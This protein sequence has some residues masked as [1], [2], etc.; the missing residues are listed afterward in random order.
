MSNNLIEC[1]I[2]DPQ[3]GKHF[4]ANRG[5]LA[6]LTLLLGISIFTYLSFQTVVVKGKSMET[7]LFEGDRLLVTHAFWLFGPPRRDD[8]VILHE[9]DDPQSP[10]IVKRLVGLGGD[11]IPSQLSPYGI[12]VVV[13]PGDAYVVGDNLANSEDSR[14]FGSVPISRIVGKVLRR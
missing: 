13:P 9:G 10:L 12:S 2:D 4:R 14:R 1:S 7:T 5:F 8:L 6:I 3:K 11:R